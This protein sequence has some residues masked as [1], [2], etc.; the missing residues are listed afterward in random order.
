MFEIRRA[1]DVYAEIPSTGPDPVQSFDHSK[2]VL[3][4]DF[5]IRISDLMCAAGPWAII[6]RCCKSA[7]S[8]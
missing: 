3:V 4:S 6:R 1:A 5:D 2:F 7:S 8:H